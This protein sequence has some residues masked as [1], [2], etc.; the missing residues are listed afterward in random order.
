MSVPAV[1]LA[2]I[3]EG[4]GP[5]AVVLSGGGAKGLAHVGVLQALEERGYDS[6]IVVGTSMGAVVGALYAAGYTPEQVR[7]RIRI[8][9][10]IR[11]RIRI[12]ICIGHLRVHNGGDR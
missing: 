5:E 6:D 2:Q 11:I 4:P 9:I 12:R 8:H 3:T 1:A 7:S 10:R